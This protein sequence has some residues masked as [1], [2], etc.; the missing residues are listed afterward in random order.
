MI[1]VSKKVL[2]AAAVTAQRDLF[3]CSTNGILF[4]RGADQ[5]T[6]A[7]STDGQRLTVI[8]YSEFATQHVSAMPLP[9][10]QAFLPLW[11]LDAARSAFRPRRSSLEAFAEPGEFYVGEGRIE[12]ADKT[13]LCSTGISYTTNV[14]AFPNWRLVHPNTDGYGKARLNADA[15]KAALKA[16]PDGTTS[17]IFTLANGS[18]GLAARRVQ[19]DGSAQIVDLGSVGTCG[20]PAARTPLFTSYAQDALRVVG[21]GCSLEVDPGG[22][23]AVFSSS[24]TLVVV[25]PQP[26]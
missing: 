9:M 5:I 10:E 25:M 26:A 24:D 3:K 22:G 2:R 19:E 15:V 4:E 18:V 20:G 12:P 23:P 7:V 14:S 8:S 6:Y 16:V 17:L 1:K 11:A 13:D 21:A